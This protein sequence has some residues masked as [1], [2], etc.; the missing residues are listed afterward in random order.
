MAPANDNTVLAESGLMDAMARYSIKP[1]SSPDDPPEQH[2]FQIYGDLAYGV[3]PH[4]L[5][6]YACVSDLSNDEHIWNMAMGSIWISV[7]HAFGCML[8]D[9]PYLNAWWKHQILGNAI[10]TLYII[11]VLLTNA[12]GCLWPNLTSEQYGCLLPS[13]AQYFHSLEE[14]REEEDSE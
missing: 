1:G 7:E 8:Q 14:D 5:S 6:P 10:G 2:F 12:H 13:L 3:S 4:I 9:W 11:G